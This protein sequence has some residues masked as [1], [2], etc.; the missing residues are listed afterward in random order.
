MISKA[1]HQSQGQDA[2]N[3]HP[4]QLFLSS[5]DLTYAIYQTPLTP[6]SRQFTAFSTRIKRLEFLRVSLG[7]RISSGAFISALYSV[8]ANEIANHSPSLYVDDVILCH[9]SFLGHLGQLRHIF[10]KLRTHNLRINPKKST[11][12]RESVAFL[13]FVFSASGVNIDSQ[14]FQKIGNIRAPTNIT[15]TRRIVGLMQYFKRHIPNFAKILSSIRQLSQKYVPFCWTAEQDQALKKLKELLLQ[16]ATLAYPDFNHEFVILVDGSKNSVGHVLAQTQGNVLRP[17]IFGGRALRKFEQSGSATH[18]ELI[19][20]L[21]AIKSHHPFL[22][23]G[24]QFLILSDHVSLRFIQNLKLSSS[25]QLVRFSLFLQH[26]NFRIKHTRLRQSFGGFSF[27]IS[28][29]SF[30][31]RG[32]GR[33]SSA[34]RTAVR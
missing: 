30:P 3:D 11:F 34:R 7:L 27:Q 25:P 32:I 14:R 15:E 1:V 12:A 29:Y 8:F 22:S 13:G 23:N 16:N 33:R 9:A 20:L 31:S 18:I 2:K 4:N 10:Q 17:L 6:E 21:D 24:R 28:F 19:G 5:F 26:F